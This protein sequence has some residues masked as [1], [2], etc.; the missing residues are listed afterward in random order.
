MSA[1]SIHML[2][3]RHRTSL[4]I[5]EDRKGVRAIARVIEN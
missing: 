3:G 4:K 2:V 1:L 5:W